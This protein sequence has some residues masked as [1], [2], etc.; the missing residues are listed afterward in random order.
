M[1]LPPDGNT[2]VALEPQ[3]VRKS[4]LWSWLTVGGVLI[5]LVVGLTIGTVLATQ[6]KRAG[7]RTN[8]P[9]PSSPA[10]SPTG[11]PT[12]TDTA[13]KVVVVAA[14]KTLLGKPK[15]ADHNLQKSA[16]TTVTSLVAA[17]PTASKAVTGIYGTSAKDM[18][19]VVAAPASITSPDDVLDAMQ[20]AISGQLTSTGAADPGPLG[21][22]ARC[23]DI[24]IRNTR[25][26]ICMWADQD[27]FGY[28]YF[29]GKRAVAVNDLFVRARGQ[30]E[31]VR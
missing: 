27:S 9:T 3:A 18:I 30:V 23:G 15:M 26:A 17:V 11:A 20:K 24:V 16:A 21:G 25:M 5:S 29:V 14:P 7:A 19:M 4:R 6:D 13:P 12:Q 1:S 2:L 28:V 8:M 22:S 31:I 10:S